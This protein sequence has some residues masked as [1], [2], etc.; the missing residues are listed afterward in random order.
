MILKPLDNMNIKNTALSK[1][2]QNS[3]EKLWNEAK[4]RIY[5]PLVIHSSYLLATSDRL[6]L[7]RYRIALI[8]SYVLKTEKNIKLIVVGFTT[9]YAISAYHH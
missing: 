4:C 9:T 8:I 1:K 6:C 2:F 5:W 3:I 7:K